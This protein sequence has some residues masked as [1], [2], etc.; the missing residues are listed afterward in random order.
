MTVVML[1]P[2]QINDSLRNPEENSSDLSCNCAEP[3]TRRPTALKAGD[4]SSIGTAFGI[5]SQ[6]RSLLY[7]AATNQFGI[8]PHF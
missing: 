1:P 8:I 7:E 5:A 3:L 4:T 6:S 2:F